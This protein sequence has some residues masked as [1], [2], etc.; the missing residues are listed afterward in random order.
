M[1]GM[2]EKEVSH[3]NR[4]TNTRRTSQWDRHWLR[5]LMVAYWQTDDESVDRNLEL[6]QSWVYSFLSDK[7][8]MNSDRIVV[9]RWGSSLKLCCSS[10]VI[11]LEVHLGYR[12]W[13]SRFS[14]WSDAVNRS[15]RPWLQCEP[16]VGHWRTPA[17]REE[18]RCQVQTSSAELEEWL[19]L[20][21]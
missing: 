18:D 17:S 14:E 15:F 11:L 4:R 13:H 20:S 5:W 3:T 10:S 7:Y 12:R 8:P 9:D 6:I 16:L 21:R 19:D 1:S 2:L